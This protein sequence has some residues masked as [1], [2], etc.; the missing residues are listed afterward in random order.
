MGTPKMESFDGLV[1]SIKTDDKGN[2]RV[3]IYVKPTYKRGTEWVQNGHPLSFML[4][5]PK[6]HQLGCAYVGSV[7]LDSN[8]KAE[9]RNQIFVR[10][11]M[12]VRFDINQVGDRTYLNAY[13]YAPPWLKISNA[14]LRRAASSSANADA[15]VLEQSV[16]II[17]E[18][19]PF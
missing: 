11:S 3:S 6:S 18:E 13:A 9:G 19:A 17:E 12:D 2:F 15:M 5:I 8:G 7:P 16:D 1:N 10:G 14:P 4:T